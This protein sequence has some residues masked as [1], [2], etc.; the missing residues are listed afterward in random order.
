MTH[1]S[2]RVGQR[3]S[4]T[5]LIV[6]VSQWRNFGGNFTD[7]YEIIFSSG[8]YITFIRVRCD[9]ILIVT[10]LNVYKYGT[11]EVWYGKQSCKFVMADGMPYFKSHKTPVENSEESLEDIEKQAC[12]LFEEFLRI[13]EPASS[14]GRLRH[15]KSEH[16]DSPVVRSLKKSVGGRSFCDSS[17]SC[18]LKVR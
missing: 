11:Q 13:T 14:A 17:F 10:L 6:T 4:M 2:N 7:F 16:S 9:T 15:A 3:L 8:V 18:F 12:L 5:N 1:V